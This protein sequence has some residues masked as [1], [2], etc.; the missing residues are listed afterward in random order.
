MVKN[1][2]VYEEDMKNSFINKIF[3]VEKNIFKINV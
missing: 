2:K 3:I 1:E